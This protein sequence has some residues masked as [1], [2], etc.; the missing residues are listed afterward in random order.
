[1]KDFLSYLGNVRGELRHVVWPKPRTAAFHTLLI[2]LISAATGVFIG[3]L[4]HGLT[5]LV[6]MFIMN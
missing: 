6:G 4:D 5:T 3:L 2:L 1:M